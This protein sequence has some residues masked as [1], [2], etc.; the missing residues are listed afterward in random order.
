MK[1][2]HCGRCGTE[3]KRSDKIVPDSVVVRCEKCDRYALDGDAKWFE[4][5][6]S[7]EIVRMLTERAAKLNRELHEDERWEEMMYGDIS[8]PMWQQL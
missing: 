7:D 4:D 6:D 2:S 3:L 5:P 1:L 8:G